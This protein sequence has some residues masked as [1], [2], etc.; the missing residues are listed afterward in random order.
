MFD[1]QVCAKS[2]DLIGFV[3]AKLAKQGL[4]RS[5]SIAHEVAHAVNWL[6]THGWNSLLEP[7]DSL[8]T[9]ATVKK[10][11]TVARFIQAEFHG[12]GP[13]QSRNFIQWLGLSKYEIP[14]DSRIV[15]VLRSL[16]FPVPLSPKALADEEYYCFI[17]DGIQLLLHEVGEYPRVFD[18][19]AF[20]SLD[21]SD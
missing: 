3:Q 4:R 2:K 8:S 15:K 16:V 21:A 1:F 20:S 5:E 9:R 14:L 7:L 10:E 17:E 19:C 13:K 12:F 6:R 18:A 11:R